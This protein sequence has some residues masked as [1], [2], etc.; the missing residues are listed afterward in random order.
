MNTIQVEQNNRQGAA[1]YSQNYDPAAANQSRQ[2]NHALSGK[3]EHV[4]LNMNRKP[5]V[6]KGSLNS[7]N[8][9]SSV[10]QQMM[11]QRAQSVSAN[12]QLSDTSMTRDNFQTPKKSWNAADEKAQQQT[13]GM[14]SSAGV[15]SNVTQTATHYNAP[16][17]PLKNPEAKFREA[18]QDLKSTHW[19]KNIEA[20]NT[21]KRVAQF[22]KELL[23]MT[24]GPLPKEAIKAIVK[25]IDSPRS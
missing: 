6:S 10:Q 23:V 5:P 8:Q 4:P 12:M 11:Q 24:S 3:S 9:Q 16:E 25:Q 15:G 18:V 7:L 2:L 22:H 21:I 14:L 13:Y 1:Q 19:E 20:Q 17:E